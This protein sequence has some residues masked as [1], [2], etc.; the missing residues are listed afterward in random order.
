MR[1]ISGGYAQLAGGAVGRTI[2]NSTTLYSLVAGKAVYGYSNN[3]DT[4]HNYNST[5]K[6]ISD[7][8]THTQAGVG[9][10]IGFE[11]IVKTQAINK[12]DDPDDYFEYEWKFGAALLDVGENVYVYG[13]QSRVASNPNANALDYQLNNKFDY[14]S[15][16]AE[17]NDSLATIVDNIAV[18][19]GKFRIWTPARFEFNVDRPL[20]EHFA[21][22]ANLTLNLG[23]NNAGK[24]LFNKD[25][26]LLALTPRWETKSLGGYLPVTVTT[27]GKVWI[28]GAFKAGPLLLGVH[29]WANLFS[30]TH[31]Q[32][33]GFYLALVLRPGKGFFQKEKKEYT[34]P[35]K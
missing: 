13:T 15:S 34:C 12:W 17:F 22:N 18:P 21:V 23:G 33:G 6:N 26:T 11:Y 29:N 4:W 16:A 27:E 1:G 8:L 9:M 28:G 14:I 25:F 20:P 35:T 32:N 10:D 2:Q 19:R 30:K 24:R 31:T 3:Y 5:G 7:F